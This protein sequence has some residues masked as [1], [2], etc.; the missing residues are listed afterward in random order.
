MQ[1]GFAFG[2]FVWQTIG[3]SGLPGTALDDGGDFGGK[4]AALSTAL[5]ALAG[6]VRG[7]FPDKVAWWRIVTD[8]HFLATAT[9]PATADLGGAGPNDL[10]EVANCLFVAAASRGEV[11]AGDFVIPGLDVAFRAEC[12]CGADGQVLAQVIVAVFEHAAVGP[13]LG[14]LCQPV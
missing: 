1:F 13:G 12:P 10:G 5:P 7:L 3:V 4:A 14:D 11:I 8:Q 9:G 2:A 6:D